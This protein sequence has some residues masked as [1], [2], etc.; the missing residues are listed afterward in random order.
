MSVAPI[1]P[2][3]IDEIV[4]STPIAAPT[5]MVAS[6]KREPVG[7]SLDYLEPTSRVLL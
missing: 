5:M 3:P 1:A 2:A 6:F 4:T 7:R